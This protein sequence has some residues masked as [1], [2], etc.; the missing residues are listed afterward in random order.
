MGIVFEAPWRKRPRNRILERAMLKRIAVIGGGDELYASL[1]EAS[2][3]KEAQVV[4]LPPGGEV[5]PGTVAIVAGADNA[6]P[7]IE[8]ALTVGG[9]NEQV[10]DLLAEAIDCREGFFVGS[11]L[12]VKDHASRFAQALDL[13]PDERSIL[14]RGAA[15]RDIGKIKI[16]NAVL[17]KEGVLTYDEWVLLQQHPE[18]GG[19]IVEHID[20]LKDTADIVRYHHEC[21][22]GD[23][24]PRGLEGDQIPF[25]AR[26]MK[27]VDV[28]CAMTSP[29]HYRKGHSSHEDAIEYLT[30]EQG[31][32]CDPELLDVFV[33]FDVGR[34]EVEAD[35]ADAG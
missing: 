19:E 17:L 29:R 23:G 18:I 5:P 13:T 16:P 22:D 10:L 1:V 9:W 21:F 24:Y 30:S 33:K 32:H 34:L 31:K 7:V 15:L 20:G 27:I 26:A 28:Y 3:G 8:A 12:R 2:Q 14:E 4:A 6:G 35:T 11:S 25:L